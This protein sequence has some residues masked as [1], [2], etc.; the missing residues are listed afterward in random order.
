[1]PCVRR[2]VNIAAGSKPSGSVTSVAVDETSYRRG[3]SYLTLA[4]DAD[5]RPLPALPNICAPRGRRYVT[6]VNIY[7]TI[8]HL[9]SP[10]RQVGYQTHSLALIHAGKDLLVGFHV[11][12]V[13]C[14]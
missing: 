13:P 3:H 10:T 14:A 12:R 11:L 1:M 6:S 5:A 8:R 2:D 9:T 4:A 7:Y